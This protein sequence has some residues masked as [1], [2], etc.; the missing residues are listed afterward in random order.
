MFPSRFTNVAEARTRFGDRVDRVGAYLSRVDPAADALVEGIRKLPEGSGW[1]L[2]ERAAKEGIAKVGGAPEVFRAFFE[3]VER[4]PVWV[5]WPTLDRGGQVLLRAGALG[6]LV[7]GLKS[8][9]LGYASPAGNK[10]L[11]LTRR[12]QEQAARRLNETAHFVQAT[13]PQGGLR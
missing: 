5:D 7:L 10:P 3:Q 1:P 12:L 13:I 6:G 9:V 8:L 11:L 4:I 2:F